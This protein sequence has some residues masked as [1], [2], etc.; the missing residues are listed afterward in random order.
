MEM[1]KLDYKIKGPGWQKYVHV[2]NI[3]E[4]VSPKKITYIPR[5]TIPW[6]FLIWN[7]TRDIETNV[8][9]L[10]FTETWF[11]KKLLSKTFFCYTGNFL[12]FVFESGVKSKKMPV[13]DN[14]NAR[15]SLWLTL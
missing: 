13:L 11:K 10:I 5:Y 12:L 15:A 3:E 2:I 8:F 1:K 9:C 4:E 14:I 7:T 6:F